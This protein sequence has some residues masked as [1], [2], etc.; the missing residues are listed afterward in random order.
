M[1]YPN[2]RKKKREKC[3]FYRGLH[4]IPDGLFVRDRKGKDLF[5]L[6]GRQGVYLFM[7]HQGPNP[8]TG[9]DQDDDCQ[10]YGKLRIETNTI[11][12]SYKF[13]KSSPNI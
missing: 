12:I 5:V 8:D 7:S 2:V 10:C 11:Y 6:C 4:V 9:F 1:Q 3:D 13:S